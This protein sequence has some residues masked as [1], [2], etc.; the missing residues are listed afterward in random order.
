MQEHP[1]P[2]LGVHCPESDQ[3]LHQEK[4]QKVRS[5]G[6]ENGKKSV[7]I[8]TKMYEMYEPAGEDEERA[9]NINI[10]ENMSTDDVAKL[11][12]DEIRLI[13]K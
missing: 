11:I 1:R 5:G 12:L 2:R 13:S 4:T 3:K 6:G 10:S 7:E 9:H 8:G